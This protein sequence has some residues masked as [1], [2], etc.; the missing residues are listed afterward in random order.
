[1]ISI[2]WFHWLPSH[3][4]TSIDSW[5]GILWTGMESND[6]NS[7]FGLF[8]LFLGLQA[9]LIVDALLQFVSELEPVLQVGWRRPADAI[10]QFALGALQL[11]AEDFHFFLQPAHLQFYQW[12]RLLFSRMSIL[13]SL[14]MN[15][16]FFA[17]QTWTS[18]VLL[19]AEFSVPFSSWRS[20]RIFSDRVLFCS[21]LACWYLTYISSIQQKENG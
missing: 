12:V 7:V 13:W 16:F 17:L 14:P 3:N 15:F 4:S 1:M 21:C 9:F 8:E 10:L 11:A 20:K 19:P 5:N 18:W 2:F 6:T